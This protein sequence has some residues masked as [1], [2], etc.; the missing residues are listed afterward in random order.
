MLLLVLTLLVFPQTVTTLKCEEEE[1]QCPKTPTS[2]PTSRETPCLPISYQ[3]DDLPKCADTSDALPGLILDFRAK[4]YAHNLNSSE[5]TWSTGGENFTQVVIEIKYYLDAR[6]TKMESTT[7]YGQT[8]RC[9]DMRPPSAKEKALCGGTPM[10][11]DLCKT[12][13][14]VCRIDFARNNARFNMLTLLET[15]ANDIT[16]RAYAS[17]HKGRGPAM[18]LSIP[19][20][21]ITGVKNLTV[22]INYKGIDTVW[23]TVTW[24]SSRFLPH[25]YLIASDTSIEYKVTICRVVETDNGTTTL[26]ECET[27]KTYKNSKKYYDLKYGRKYVFQVQPRSQYTDA[28]SGP[29]ESVYLTLLSKEEPTRINVVAMSL[30]LIVALFFSP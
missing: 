18:G 11:K 15:G 22:T 20:P 24:N 6:T 14:G 13:C 25:P 12:L 28:I 16:A 29:M 9:Y 7:V 26:E 4:V 1:Y 2:P 8:K 27:E 5:F 19:I 3:C 30:S 21:K 10:T 23:V 17:N